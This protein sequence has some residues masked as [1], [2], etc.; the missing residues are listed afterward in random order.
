MSEKLKPIS[1]EQFQAIIAAVRRSCNKPARKVRDECLLSLMFYYAMRAHE[2]GLLKMADVEE[3]YIYIHAG[4]NGV[5]K[6]YPLVDAVI[7]PLANWLNIHLG[8]EYLFP[9]YHGRGISRF[10]PYVIVGEYANM[11]GIPIALQHP[12][13]F[14]H[15]CAVYLLELGLDIYD[16]KEWLRHRSLSS[17]IEYLR[18][19]DKRRNAIVNKINGF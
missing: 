6:R 2:P 5:S 16:A 13:T 18:F 15:G 12:H 19:T 17:T 9:G 1:L 14:R 4:K 10:V 11:A 8:G 3:K 7:Q